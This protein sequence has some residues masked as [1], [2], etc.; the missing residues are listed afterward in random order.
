[1][2]RFLQIDFLIW[3]I[4]AAIANRYRDDGIDLVLVGHVIPPAL[5]LRQGLAS[6]PLDHNATASGA[7]GRLL[8]PTNHFHQRTER[9]VENAVLVPPAR[10]GVNGT[11]P[12]GSAWNPCSDGWSI[13]PTRTTRLFTRN[14]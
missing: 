5:G 4:F 6:G 14:R 1:V 9:K 7:M 11:N 13:Y 3:M 8:A 2:F 10:P 12:S